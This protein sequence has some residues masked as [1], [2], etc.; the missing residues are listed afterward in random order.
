MQSLELL[1]VDPEPVPGTQ[2]VEA[3]EALFNVF[4]FESARSGDPE[5]WK[6]WIRQPQRGVDATGPAQRTTCTLR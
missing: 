3:R 2:V 6:D 4:L 1:R 5:H